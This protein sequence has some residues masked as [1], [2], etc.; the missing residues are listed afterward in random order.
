M[1]LPQE[2]L[3][4][5]QDCYSLRDERDLLADVA[6]VLVRWALSAAAAAGASSSG[7]NGSGGGPEPQALQALAGTARAQLAGGLAASG[8]SPADLV[9]HQQL[10]W[11]LDELQHEG[12]HAAAGEAGRGLDLQQLR[13]TVLPALLHQLWHAWHAA[14]WQARPAHTL[15]AGPAALEAAAGSAAALAVLRSS[16]S[17]VQS[18]A[19]RL[20]QLRLA[21]VTLQ[22]V[23][24][25][26]R[27]GSGA[28]AD[29]GSLG[30][31]SLACLFGQ[32][33]LAHASALPSTSARQG[34][35]QAVEVL[36]ATAE[37]SPLS[38]TAAM[39]PVSEVA[40]GGRHVLAQ[41]SA[42]L[43][44]VDHRVLAD[45]LQPLVLPCCATLLEGMAAARLAQQQHAANSRGCSAGGGGSANSVLRAAARLEALQ[46]RDVALRGR[47]WLLLGLLRLQLVAPP[48][49]VDPAGK[50]GL[51]LRHAE[52]ELLEV[53]QPEIM[54]GG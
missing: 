36:V 23:A 21:A 53:V 34:L 49:G 9:P 3:I 32:L 19:V 15:P 42:A 51:Q 1:G 10:L 31:H 16:A 14:S 28:A 5:L 4:R 8:R 44:S 47:A 35:A 50:Y 48:P 12:S 37:A 18:K 52:G 43:A 40:D 39:A 6:A 41:L 25:R 33:L 11:V 27:T 13:Q 17:S 29:G 2:P 20:A 22:R 30:W 54:V 45:V 24:A 26:S 38:S 46:R 7:S